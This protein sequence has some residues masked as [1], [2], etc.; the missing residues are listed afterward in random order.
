MREGNTQVNVIEWEDINRAYL[1]NYFVLDTSWMIPNEYH[2]DIKLT[3]NLQ[4][5]TLT[6]S[7]KFNI[8]N[9]VDQLH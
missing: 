2:I 3:S 9:Q 4:V 8:V 1:K 5:K 7:I 6:D